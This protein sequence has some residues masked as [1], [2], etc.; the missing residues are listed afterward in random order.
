LPLRCNPWSA[1]QPQHDLWEKRG[2][3]DQQQ[4]QHDEE[5]PALF[6]HLANRNAGQ[7]LGHKQQHAKG[8]VNQPN[9]H[10]QHHQHA[11]VHQV[12]AQQFG[13][14]QQHGHKHQQQHRHIQK[15]AQHQKHHIHQQQK[16]DGGQV[17]AVHPQ[18]HGLRHAFGGEG[19]VEHEG[20]RQNHGDDRAA[21]VDSITTPQKLRQV[22]AL[23]TT[24]PESMNARPPPQQPRSG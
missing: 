3:G 11:K 13:R 24:Q 10:V 4:Q 23:N 2:H 12:D 20:A 7:R 21:P 18:R 14:G 19:V 9:H 5:G 22:S 17:H 15:A 6:H 8:R 1:G 16:L